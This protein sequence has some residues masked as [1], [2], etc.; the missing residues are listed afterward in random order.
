GRHLRG[1][2]GQR[3]RWSPRQVRPR[4]LDHQRV[5]GLESAS[6]GAILA[7]RQ[8]GEGGAERM[9]Q[10]GS[11]I[12]AHGE[13][14]VP[15]VEFAILLPVLVIMLFGLIQFGIAFNTK[16]QATNRAREG[17]RMAAFGAA[18]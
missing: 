1:T 11:G 10:G 7:R 5:E 6:G 12:T 15:A 9:G 4:R 3:G 13:G 14:G 16:I 17:A 8:T 2:P 18:S